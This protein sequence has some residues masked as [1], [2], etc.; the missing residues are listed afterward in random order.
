MSFGVCEGQISFTSR[1]PGE[2]D[3]VKP[4]K[5]KI[6]SQVWVQGAKQTKA[7]RREPQRQSDFMLQVQNIEEEEEPIAQR[8]LT[9]V[10]GAVWGDAARAT[11]KLLKLEPAKRASQE[12]LGGAEGES[13]WKDPYANLVHSFLV[14]NIERS[15]AGSERSE[16]LNQSL[17]AEFK[18]PEQ[19]H[20][21]S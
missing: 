12:N 11:R 3:G 4:G 8:R 10:P 9:K 1:A 13:L 19:E 17:A 14:Q 6:P 20:A 21:V 2:C 7:L 18:A 5:V 15:D 16:P